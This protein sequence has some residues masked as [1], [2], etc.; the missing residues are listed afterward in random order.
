M[1]AQPEKSRQYKTIHAGEDAVLTPQ[2]EMIMA[3][4]LAGKSQ[5]QAGKEAGVTARYVND[6]LN[7]PYDGKTVSPVMLR[8]REE[9]ERRLTEMRE[10]EMQEARLTR[11]AC[12]ERSLEIYDLSMD[13]KQFKNCLSANDQ[14]IKMLGFY[15][16]KIE[17]TG[18]D[19]G[20][21]RH[22]HDPKAGLINVTELSSQARLEI[23]EQLEANDA[24]R[25]LESG[26]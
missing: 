14:I 26:D 10:Q 3:A 24:T 20:A 25:A 4:L 21:I 2:H 16:T 15:T 1:P 22:E 17:H 19:G 13:K 9:Y 11:K 5:T 18:K 8:F 12:L 6:L 7:R 23:L